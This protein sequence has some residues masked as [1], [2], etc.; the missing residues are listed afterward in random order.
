MEKVSVSDYEE[1]EW[2]RQKQDI[3]GK[4]RKRVLSW[5][6]SECIDKN[7]LVAAIRSVV[8]RY[9]RLRAR[10]QFSA[11]G[12]LLMTPDAVASVVLVELDMARDVF[13]LVHE[14]QNRRWVPEVESPFSAIVACAGE[15][16]MVY[17]FMHPI[18]NGSVDGEG[19]IDEVMDAYSREIERPSSA[20]RADANNEVN[21][22]ERCAGHL[23]RDGDASEV[24]NFIRD[25]ILEVFRD[26][27]SAPNMGADD[28]F[29]DFGGHSLIATR[30][31]GRLASEDGIEL[32]FGDFFS[33]PTASTLATC[34]RRSNEVGSLPSQSADERLTSELVPLSEV[35]SSLWAAYKAF[36]FG[37]I[38]NLPFAMELMDEVDERLL[39][40]AFRDVMQRHEILRA[41]FSDA[42]GSV[43]QYAIPVGMLGRYKWFWSSEESQGV[44][45]ADEANYCFDLARELPVR[46]RVLRDAETGKQILSFLVHHLVIDEWS[47]NVIM[48]D[49]RKAYEARSSGSAPVWA[50]AA[51]SFLEFASLGAQSKERDSHLCYW[52]SRLQGAPRS[53]GLPFQEG[54]DSSDEGNNTK[55]GWLVLPLCGG[56]VDGLY[57]L[58][59]SI[60]VSI[61]SIVYA[62]I[63]LSVFRI[64]G[65]T[66]M[67]FGTSASGR[68]DYRYHD[69]VGYFTVM[70]AH[71][72]RLDPAQTLGRLIY[73]VGE[74]INESMPYADV[75]I[76]AIGDAL[77]RRDGDGL[78]FE[79]YVQI[80]ARNALNGVLIS[81]SGEKVR[82]RQIDPDKKETMFDLQFEIMED[83]HETFKSLRLVITYRRCR[84][85]R[86]NMEALGSMI[87]KMLDFMVSSGAMEVSVMNVPS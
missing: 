72:V 35:Q 62:A 85:S 42:D 31:M 32:S 25:R 14:I 2:L 48:D 46:V 60:G 27:L 40:E 54:T 61:F 4:V 8:E 66:D 18:L 21:E 45:L 64:G 34:V 17:L 78:P 71:R 57:A 12:E 49:L 80:H 37:V 24:K 38:F 33:H 13:D 28:D 16:T 41:L 23:S 22:T 70:V 3:A 5:A 11:A 44:T 87:G 81:S 43:G 26:S 56:T 29:F 68:T 19:I 84:Y 51:P 75:P 74:L 76:S 36:G 86:E 6:V 10:Y 53:L 73:D 50:H 9:P 7:G 55:A 79:A 63:S 65:A 39:E 20:P 52:V 67:V 69:S 82:F 30:I 1:R 47:V 58:S 77:G 83:V 59:K 15:Y